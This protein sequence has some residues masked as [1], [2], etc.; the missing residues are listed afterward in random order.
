MKR[1]LSLAVLFCAILISAQDKNVLGAV[2]QRDS[3]L[4]S[5]NGESITLLDVILESNAEEAKLASQELA[6]RLSHLLYQN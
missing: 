6:L 5:V 1:F 2:T 4:A 3:I